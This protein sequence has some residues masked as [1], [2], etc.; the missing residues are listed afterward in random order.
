MN[1]SWYKLAKYEDNT[2]NVAEAAQNAGYNSPK[3]YHFTPHDKFNSFDRTISKDGFFFTDSPRSREFGKTTIAVYLSYNKPYMDDGESGVL[4]G[5]IYQAIA[6]HGYDAIISDGNIT[7]ERIH[8]IVVF[9]PE[10]IK[11]ADPITYDDQG[12]EIPLEERFNRNN[13]DIRY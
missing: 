9:K 5:R 6:D 2:Q 3:L 11:S 13:P 4:D 12:N 8:E 10:Q 7:G 1:T